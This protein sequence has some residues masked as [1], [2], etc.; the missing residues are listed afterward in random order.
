MATAAADDDVKLESFLQWLQVAPSLSFPCPVQSFLSSKTLISEPSLSA[1][2]QRRRPPQLHDPRM[3]R[4][5][6]GRLL[7]RRPRAGLQ[8]R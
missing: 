4:Q 7:H 1:A 2:V 5:G 6:L 3:R 8:R